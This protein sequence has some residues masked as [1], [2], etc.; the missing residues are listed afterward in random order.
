VS[1]QGTERVNAKIKLVT[2]SKK[3]STIAP[4]HQGIVANSPLAAILCPDRQHF[5]ACIFTQIL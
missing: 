4:L 1:L 3:T 2:L 5:E